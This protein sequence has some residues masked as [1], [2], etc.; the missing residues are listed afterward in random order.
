MK[1]AY[2]EIKLVLFMPGNGW[3]YTARR[4]GEVVA[5]SDGD[6]HF[7]TFAKAAAGCFTELQALAKAEKDEVDS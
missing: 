2:L 6:A 1:P 3:E 7:E 4:F 5:A